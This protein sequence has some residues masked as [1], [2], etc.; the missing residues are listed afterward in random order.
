M[1][2][3]QAREALEHANEVRM[4]R[5]AFKR[6]L[7][8]DTHPVLLV[9]DMLHATPSWAARWRVDDALRSIP[10]WGQARTTRALR[11]ASIPP[12]TRLDRLTERQRSALR[13]ELHAWASDKRAA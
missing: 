5:A 4:L 1:S 3:T 9:L 10:G 11:R 6:Q 7:H 12:R 8:G 2:A 13:L